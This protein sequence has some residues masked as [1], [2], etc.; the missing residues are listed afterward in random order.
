ML[1]IKYSILNSI[2]NLSNSILIYGFEITQIGLI[3]DLLSL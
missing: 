3:V 1:K 2:L